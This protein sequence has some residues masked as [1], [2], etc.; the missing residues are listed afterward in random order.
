MNLNELLSEQ[1]LAMKRSEIRELLKLTSVPGMISFGGGLPDPSLFPLKRIQDVTEQ[2]I[3]EDGVN[4]LQYGTTEG[5]NGL[6]KILVERYRKIGFKIGLENLI[7]VTGS[8]QALD[9]TGKIFVNPK[10]KIICEAPSYLGSLGAFLSYGADICDI[11]IDNEGINMKELRECYANLEREQQKPKYLYLIPDYQNPSGIHMSLQRRKEVIEFAREKDLLLIEDSPYKEFNFEGESLASLFELWENGNVIHF[12]TFSKT[13]MPGLR[14]GWIIA[15]EEI[16]DRYVIAKQN[17][18][19][20][21]SPLN[22]KICAKFIEQGYF[23]DYLKIVK[24]EYKKKRDAMLKDFEEFM[25]KEVSWNS[26]NGGLFL[27]IR[28]PEGIDSKKLFDKAIEKRVAYVPGTAFFV[29]GKGKDF[30]RINFSYS[31]IE[32]NREGVKRLAELIKSEIR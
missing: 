6:R 32:Q 31:S 20:C 15:S 19:L 17:T 12:G 11:P 2:V 25:P 13:F 28:F 10:D 4:A 1:H 24:I 21:S 30:A 3:M 22:Q 7:I 9:L 23:D 18:D 29:G 8:Q 5:D 16:I 27:F 26:P 14:L